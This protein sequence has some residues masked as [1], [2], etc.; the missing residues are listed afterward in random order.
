M[1]CSDFQVHFLEGF[2]EQDSILNARQR[3]GHSRAPWFHS[4]IKETKLQRDEVSHAPSP[5][6]AWRANNANTE[7]VPPEHSDNRTGY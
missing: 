6:S 7:R 1:R 2:L 4:T 5:W 3:Y